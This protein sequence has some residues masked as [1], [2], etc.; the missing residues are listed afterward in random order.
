MKKLNENSQQYTINPVYLIKADGH[1]VIDLDTYPID[2]LPRKIRAMLLSY[3][4]DTDNIQDIGCNDYSEN[5]YDGYLTYENDGSIIGNTIEYW[6]LSINFIANADIQG[7]EV[8]YDPGDY[9]TPPYGGFTEIDNIEIEITDLSIYRVDEEFFNMYSSKKWIDWCYNYV[10]DEVED[11][12][13]QEYE[14][15]NN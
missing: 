9:Y 10:K 6:E 7:R 11:T 5:E 12:C 2:S 14:K 1:D 4:E 8:P 3:F 15:N 13:S